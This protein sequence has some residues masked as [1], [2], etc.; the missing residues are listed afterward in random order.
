VKANDADTYEIPGSPNRAVSFD[1]LW[2][3][4]SYSAVC[5]GVRNSPLGITV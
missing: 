4:L 3:A 1:H 5:R 2:I